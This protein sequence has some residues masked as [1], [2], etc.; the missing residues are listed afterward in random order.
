[1]SLSELGFQISAPPVSCSMG[2][3]KSYLAEEADHYDQKLFFTSWTLIAD[4]APPFALR[5]S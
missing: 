1:M 2:Y 3:I 5:N 4:T